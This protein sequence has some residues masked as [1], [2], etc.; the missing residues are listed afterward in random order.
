[1]VD[2]LY[3]SMN[4][5]VDCSD[6][7]QRYLQA[8][9][10]TLITAATEH[11]YLLHYLIDN[12]FEELGQP[13]WVYPH[14]FYAS[15]LVFLC[16]QH[17]ALTLARADK[18]DIEYPEYKAKLG[19]YIAEAR[20]VAARAVDRCDQESRPYVFL[21][22]DSTPNSYDQCL[23]RV[24]DP[25]VITVFRN[26]API[27]GSGFRVLGPSE[28]YEAFR[29]PEP[30]G[31]ADG[32]A[33][34]QSRSTTEAATTTPRAGAYRIKME[35]TFTLRADSAVESNLMIEESRRLIEQDCPQAQVVYQI[36]PIDTAAAVDEW[37]KFERSTH[38]L[39]IHPQKLGGERAEEM[40]RLS[41]NELSPPSFFGQV[42]ADFRFD[43]ESSEDAT[44][45]CVAVANATARPASYSQITA[46]L[47]EGEGSGLIVGYV[48]V[49][50]HDRAMA[51]RFSKSQSPS[52]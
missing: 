20:D 50:V 49:S 2:D 12:V 15:G 45:K 35:G 23:T 52:S 43:A 37:D 36:S 21:D 11:G 6:I 18:P 46:E 47:T 42:N 40:E 24:K 1:M 29:P 33:E 3:K 31:D 22:T 8:T 25:G 27:E 16:P 9:G 41:Y 48:V 34:G 51:L 17:F 38:D 44:N 28:I 19:Y 4:L 14:W 32:T 39:F 26:E 30:G 13:L 5:A 10:R 7:T